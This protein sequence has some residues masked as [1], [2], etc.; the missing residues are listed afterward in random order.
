MKTRLVALAFAG[1]LAVA[2]V[3]PAFAAPP[4]V[5]DSPA[6]PNAQCGT[7]ASSGAFNFHNLVYAPNSSAFGQAGGAGGGQTGL[8]NSAVCG[9]RP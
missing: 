1:A 3:V 6:A 9:N 8:N 5:G 2:A 4:A 7:A